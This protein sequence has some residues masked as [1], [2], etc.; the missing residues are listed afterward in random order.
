MK[1][2]I[3]KVLLAMI[4]SACGGS[5]DTSVQSYQYRGTVAGTNCFG[6]FPESAQISYAVTIDALAA[7]SSV[8][9]L[10]QM[11]TTWTGTMTTPSSFK[12][13]NATPNADPRTSIVVSG[14]TSSEAHVDATT[15]CV[16]F[17]C[18]TTLSGNVGS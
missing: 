15:S 2:K 3:A 5:S 9:L 1:T 17:R 18:C 8:T 14:I 10:D 16:S 13:T 7:G 11:G 4:L 12:V 6:G